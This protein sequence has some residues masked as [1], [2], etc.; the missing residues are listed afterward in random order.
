MSAL[1]VVTAIVADGIRSNLNANRKYLAAGE[2]K[3]IAHDAAAVSIAMLI[4][5]T[6]GHHHIVKA[7]NESFTLQHPIV[8]RLTGELM[9]CDIHARIA[10]GEPL[11]RGRYRVLMKDDPTD[12]DLVPLKEF[13]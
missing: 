9:D 12:Y 8:E 13:E 3:D 11:E 6:G 1:D 2:R 10:A 4:D 5:M 7:T